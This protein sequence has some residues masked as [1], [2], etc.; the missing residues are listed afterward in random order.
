MQP[1]P[2]P[3]AVEPID[4]TKWSDVVDNAAP[5]GFPC[6]AASADD[7]GYPDMSFKGS[8]MVLDRDHL[9]WWEWSHGTQLEQI[10]RQPRVSVLYRS[11]VT[12]LFLRW[13]GE[14]TIVREGPLRDQVMSRTPEREL[15]RDP[16]RQGVAVVVRVDQVRSGNSVV[17]QRTPS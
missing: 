2:V 7:T 13:Y 10:E 8:L 3:P 16:E 12:K 15:A 17:Q 4:L 5:E 1:T 6:I 11:T 14:A 9:A